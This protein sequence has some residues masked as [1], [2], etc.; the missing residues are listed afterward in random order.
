[1]LNTII[2]EMKIKTTI[3]YHLTSVRM[4]IINQSTNTRCQKKGDHLTLLVGMKLVQSLWK[5]AWRFLRKL[6]IE[7]P[8]DPEIPLLAIYPDKTL[9]Q[10]DTCT[11]MFIV[12]LYTLAKALY[13]MSIYR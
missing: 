13:T 4:A 5:T 6:N 11:P 10:K 1:M 7:L 3:R 12:A 8:H 2:R 9:I